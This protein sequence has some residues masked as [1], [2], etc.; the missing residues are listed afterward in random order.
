MAVIVGSAYALAASLIRAWFI[1]G[2]SSSRKGDY[3]AMAYTLV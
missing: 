1:N 3:P 2:E